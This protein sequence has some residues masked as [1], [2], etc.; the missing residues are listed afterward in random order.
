M[1]HCSAMNSGRT[2]GSQPCAF[3]EMTRAR[4]I[5]TSVS[6]TAAV[7]DDRIPISDRSSDRT[8]PGSSWASETMIA[9]PPSTGSAAA[10]TQKPSFRRFVTHGSLPLMTIPSP[11]ARAVTCRGSSPARYFITFDRAEAPARSPARMA[12]NCAARSSAF[13]VWTRNSV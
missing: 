6:V 13:G 1:A 2:P 4:G 7:S 9:G 11:S 10:A 5:R 3:C 8:S 12:G